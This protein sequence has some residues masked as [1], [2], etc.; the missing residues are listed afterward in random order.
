MMEIEISSPNNGKWGGGVRLIALLNG[1]LPA[2]IVLVLVC[3]DGKIGGL[4]LGQARLPTSTSSIVD[5]WGFPTY[6]EA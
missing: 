4:I 3:E 6:Y 2:L 1:V 5:I